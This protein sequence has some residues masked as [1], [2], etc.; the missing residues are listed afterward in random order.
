MKILWSIN[1]TIE[2][3][4]PT[5]QLEE[6]TFCTPMS[7]SQMV[8]KMFGFL[9][10]VHSYPS[11]WPR[12]LLGKDWRNHDYTYLQCYCRVLP[13]EGLGP[14]LVHGFRVWKLA[15]VQQLSKRSWLGT[16]ATTFSLLIELWLLLI[17]QIEQ[18]P[19]HLP[20]YFAPRDA[21]FH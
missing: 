9:S 18:H 6:I 14:H 20:I 8:L 5:Y 17:W 2:Y 19:C 13:P 3:S 21:I 10:P 11:K 12:V 7:I 16:R 15:Y 1:C 4:L